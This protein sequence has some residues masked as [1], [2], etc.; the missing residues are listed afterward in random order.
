MGKGRWKVEKC[1]EVK[2][3]SP[4]VLWQSHQRIPGGVQMTS[5][6]TME[7]SQ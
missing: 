1:K 7:K 2:L 4:F 5:W 6:L 3:F